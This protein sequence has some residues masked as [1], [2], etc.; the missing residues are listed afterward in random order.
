MAQKPL[1][2]NLMVT[3]FQGETIVS[4]EQLFSNYVSE[5]LKRPLDRQKYPHG[6]A[7]YRDEDTKKWLTYLAGQL[8]ADK[9]TV[10]LVEKMRPYW[11]NSGVEI[12]I[13]RL[14]GGLIFG[15]IWGL[16]LCLFFGLYGLIS[17]L[18][19]GLDEWDKKDN[20]Q[21][22][23]FE[24]TRQGLESGLIDGLFYGLFFGLIS[25][26]IGGLIGGL[27]WGLIGGLCGLINGLIKNLN[28]EIKSREKPN[29][30][31]KESLKKTLVFYLIPSLFW[32]LIFPLYFLIIG[33]SFDWIYYIYLGLLFGFVVA[34]FTGGQ[35]LIQHL[36]LRLI[37]V[38]QKRIPRNYARFLDYAEER[39]F[40]HKI[41]GQYR[42]LHDSLR[43]YFASQA[44]IPKR[45]IQESSWYRILFSLVLFFSWIYSLLLIWNKFS[46][47]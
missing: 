43:K 11:L 46:S 40:I 39:K 22:K 29:Q 18:I 7:P 3:A 8:E 10:F 37:L 17:G 34:L 35:D 24:F 9:L 1:F 25:G 15:L 31:I 42:F 44:P 30:G 2:L 23:A 6:K 45:V 27:I 20:I 5:Q 36:T 41:G 33:K 13:F 14:I 32:G 16:I 47:G 21:S 28:T 4:E 19:F 12:W 38:Q 26:L